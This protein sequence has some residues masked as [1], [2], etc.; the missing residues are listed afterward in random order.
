MRENERA[1]TGA[2]G[3]T[4]RVLD[5]GV[6]V[7]DVLKAGIRDLSDEVLANHGLH[8]RVG[9]VAQFVEPRAG[10]TVTTEDR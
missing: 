3:G 4:G 7:D 8:V 2:G 5:R 9:T 10:D 1:H 6:V